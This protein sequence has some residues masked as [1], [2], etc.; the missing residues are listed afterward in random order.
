MFS[1]VRCSFH[2]FLLSDYPAASF[3]ALTNVAGMGLYSI[4]CRRNFDAVYYTFVSFCAVAELRA[5][6]T[7]EKAFLS[8]I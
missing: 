7:L 8:N 3:L 1:Y 6:K 5:V 2:T 4:N